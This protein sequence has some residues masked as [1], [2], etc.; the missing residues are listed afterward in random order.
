MNSGFFSFPASR[1]SRRFGALLWLLLVLL[2]TAPTGARADCT[3]DKIQGNRYYTS[4][5]VNFTISS[6]ITIPFTLTPGATLANSGQTTPTSP[7]SVT[8]TAGTSYGVQ[9]LVGG[10]PTGGTNYIYPTNVPGVGFQLIHADNTSAFMGPYPNYS[11]SAGSSTYSV[12]TALVLVQTGPIANGSSLAAGTILAAWQWGSITPE[13]FVLANKVTFTSPACTASTNPIS[14]QL[15]SVSSSA[16]AG[17]GKTAGTTSFNIQ[18]SCPTGAT[19]KLSITL[20]ANNGT[21]AGYPNILKNTGT[22]TG[23]GIQIQDGGGNPVTLGTA[24]VIGTAVSGPQSI[25]YLAA[26]YSTAASVGQGSVAT[27]ATFTL[28]YQ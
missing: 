1:L 8:C 14:V 19:S 25:P 23:L 18:L 26:Y 28:T 20:A 4:T 12:N 7:P 27:A 17:A 2:A 22:A 24:T 16:F 3:Y 9:N 13:T 10:A 21:V 15:P 6:T 5:P 11:A